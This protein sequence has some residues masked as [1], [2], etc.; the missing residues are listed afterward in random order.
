[1]DISFGP[2]YDAYREQV[3]SFL[4]EKWGAGGDAER[5]EDLGLAPTPRYLEFAA[6]AIEAGYYCPF[7][8]KKYGGAEQPFD[9]IK[10]VIISREFRKLGVKDV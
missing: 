6:S 4:E 9:P 2:E 10:Q 1:M 3:R 8:P 5:D 7:L